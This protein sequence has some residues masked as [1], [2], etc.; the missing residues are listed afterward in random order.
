MDNHRSVSASLKQTSRL[1]IYSQLNHEL[2]NYSER[3]ATVPK[4]GSSEFLNSFHA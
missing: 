3:V 2:R 1:T 4:L